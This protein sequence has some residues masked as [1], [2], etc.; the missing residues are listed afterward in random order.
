MF[1]S[2]IYYFYLKHEFAENWQS[3][4]IEGVGNNSPLYIKGIDLAQ[5]R[6]NWKEKPTENKEIG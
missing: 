1:T 6:S 4:E 2:F 3:A 5:G